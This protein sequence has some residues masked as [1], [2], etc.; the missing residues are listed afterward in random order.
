MKKVASGSPKQTARALQPLAYLGLGLLWAALEGWARLHYP[1]GSHVQGQRLSEHT[2][3][4]SLILLFVVW[5]AR[6]LKVLVFRRALG[7]GAF[8]FAVLH[9]RYAFEHVLGNRWDGIFFLTFERQISTWVGLAALILM[10]P[11]ALTSSDG[12]VRKLGIWWKRLH[13]SVLMVMVLAAL[14]TAYMGVHYGLNSPR[15]TTLVLLL[16][17]SAILLARAFKNRTLKGTLQRKSSSLGFK[18]DV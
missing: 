1:D 13:S 5:L 6:P 8:F 7:L 14:H 2:G 4:A 11:L 18:K 15:A 3:N 12:A 17:L 9:T 10:V 16:S